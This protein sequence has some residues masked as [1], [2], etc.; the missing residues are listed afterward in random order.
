MFSVPPTTRQ[1]A[2]Q[3]T[4]APGRLPTSLQD[5]ERTWVPD[6]HSQGFVRRMHEKEQVAISPE[7]PSAQGTLRVRG[8]CIAKALFSE[9]SDRRDSRCSENQGP[10]AAQTRRS[11]AAQQAH[12]RLGLELPESMEMPKSKSVTEGDTS[13]G[14]YSPLP[15]TWPQAAARR[16]A[17][18]H[19]QAAPQAAREGEAGQEGQLHSPLLRT[20]AV[21]PCRGH[22]WMASRTRGPRPGALDSVRVAQSHRS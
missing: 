13:W 21:H 15:C 17:S 2:A 4:D 12:G 6:S 11:S 22:L 3:S 1:E 5:L 10:P 7:S 19:P 14:H 18:G 8:A 20:S 9:R 16:R